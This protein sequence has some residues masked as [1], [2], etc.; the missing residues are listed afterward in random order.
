MNVEL[1]IGTIDVLDS[2]G[3]GPVVV[4]LHG[5][6]MNASLWSEVVDQL[7]DGIRTIV[8][9]LPM[10]AHRYPAHADADLSLNGL[11]AAVV[12]LLEKL[13]LDDVTLVGNDTGG[14]IA[15]LVAGS[16]TAR[17]GRLVLVS[18]EAFDNLPPGLT[19][20]AI[21]LTGRL[22]LPLFGLAMQ[23]LRVRPLR[24]LPFTFGWLTRSGDK[25]V[26][27]WLQPLLTDRRIR[28]DAVRLLRTIPRE[29]AALAAASVKLADFA[30][31]AL[32]VWAHGDRVM[33]PAHG[34]RLAELLD[35]ALI[36]APLDVQNSHTLIPLDQPR[37]LAEELA[38]FVECLDHPCEPAAQQGAAR[39]E[40]AMSSAKPSKRS[41]RRH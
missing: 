22:P 19:G 13:D 33:P 36:D 24:R 6:L 16:G 31:P 39:T 20:R 7:P 28:K 27:A 10:G 26:R 23:Q 41:R 2:G 1:A 38:C 18:C 17:L 15:Q 12:E 21:V 14:A 29:K 40:P 11:A 3:S 35:A 32:V 37:L 4:L 5:L 30:R 25:T 34:R 9:T 8:P